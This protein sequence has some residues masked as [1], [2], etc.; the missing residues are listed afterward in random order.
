MT[1]NDKTFFVAPILNRPATSAIWP[2]CLV[3]LQGIDVGNKIALHKDTI[4]IGRAQDMDICLT[5]G[6]VSRMH[7]VIQRLNEQQ[8]LLIDK[9]S[10]NGTLVNSQVITEIL[11]KDQDVIRIGDSIL[12]FIASDSPEQSYYEELYRQT[13]LDKALQIYNK[14]YFLNKLKEE[15]L[16]CQRYGNELSLILFDVD[17]FKQFNDT[18]GHLAGDAALIQLAEIGKKHLR[19]TDSLCRYGGEEF[20]VIMPRTSQQQA[21][22]LSENIRTIVSK[23]PVHYS[24]TAIDMTI[25]I[26]ITSYSLDNTQFIRTPELLIAQA[27]K[28]LY[29]AKH[30][31]RNKVILFNDAL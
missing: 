25:S 9:N 6:G 21:Y 11:L 12:K 23:T 16:S 4:T 29:Q 14:H 13:H 5:Q 17:H 19:E 1:D 8:F 2:S 22:V 15:I 26:G 10:T 24:G 3:V 20:T 18:Y 31:G 30:S 28:A 7:A 27:D